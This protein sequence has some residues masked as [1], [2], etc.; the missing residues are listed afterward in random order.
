MHNLLQVAA[1]N[2][3][4]LEHAW[5]AETA[6]HSVTWGQG[7]PI[8]RGQCGVS[9]V[10][11]ARRL[12]ELDYDAQVAEGTLELDDLHQG[13][14]WV[15]VNRKDETPWVI[16]VTCDQFNSINRSKVH[17]GEYDSGPGTIGA[18]ALSELFDPY[19]NVH[20]KLMRRHA[21]LEANVANLSRRQQLQI[22]WAQRHWHS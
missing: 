12:I 21:L 3:I 9:S 20:G 5:S 14:V 16:D 17:I 22:K 7:E 1:Q 19:A 11:L 6:H 15:Q 4:I 13:F 10:W 18:Y 8:S 2:R